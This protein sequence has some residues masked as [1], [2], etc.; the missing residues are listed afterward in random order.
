MIEE[1]PRA[2]AVGDVDAIRAGMASFIEENG[3]DELILVSSV[4]DHQ[5]RLRSYEITMEA[6]KSI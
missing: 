1:M 2:A 3:A 6:A 5:A 4:Y